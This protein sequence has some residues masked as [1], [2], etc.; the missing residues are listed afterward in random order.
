MARKLNYGIL[1]A[2]LGLYLVGCFSQPKYTSTL[3][4]TNMVNSLTDMT[5]LA[6]LDAPAAK[7][8]CSYD[9][10]NGNDDYNNPLRRENG[11]DVLFDQDG[12][13]YIS[14]FWFTGPE[15]GKQPFEF[16]FDGER[17][18]SLRVTLDDITSLPPIAANEP[19]CWFSY[20]PIP[21][22]KHLK[23]RTTS[24]GYKE[25]GMP[26]LFY[27]INYNQLPKGTEVK[28]YPQA[29]DAAA[30]QALARAQ[31]VWE[32][33]TTSFS[34][35][36]ATALTNVIIPA[37]KS[38]E[39]YQFK[40]PAMLRELCMSLDRSGAKSA[41]AREALLR[42]LII[43][44]YWNEMA[45][46]SVEVPFGD[47]FGSM[48]QRLHYQSL[49]LGCKDDT[50]FVR[51]PMPFEKTARI[52]VENRSPY[53][54]QIGLSGQLEP[55]ASWTNK[56]G[57]FHAAWQKSKSSDVGKPH[58][59]LRTPGRGKYVG[60][61]LGTMSDDKSWW[62][63]EGDELIKVGG[64]EI[65][66]WH[67]TG[68]EDYFDA[69]WYYR[70]ALV[71]AI[72]GLPFKAPFRTIQYRIH[73]TCSVAFSNGIEVAWERGPHNE[74]HGGMESVAYYYLANPAGAASFLGDNQF[75]Q[76]LEDAL[77]AH[78]VMMELN[79]L[80]RLG[81]YSGA[82]E[83][84]DTFLEKYPQFPQADILRVRQLGYRGLKEGWSSVEASYNK[85]LS[86]T[87]TS[88]VLRQQVQK[89]LDFH[90]QSNNVLLGIY[91]NMPTRVYLD[92]QVI[93][94]FSDP[95][96]MSYLIK[97]LSS[98]TK[99]HSLVMQCAW[100]PY[101]FW[102]QGILR[103]HTEDIMTGPNWKIALNPPGKWWET[104]YDDSKWIPVGGLGVKG[105][106]EEPYILLEPNIFVDMMSKPTGM[107]PTAIDWP[108]HN[109]YV[110]YRTVF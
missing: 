9:R 78:T 40:G 70:N 3:P 98:G 24:G 39:L 85:I 38:I 96:R 58:L 80:E 36:H 52:E 21:Y 54:C 49:Y 12:P 30:T 103:T 63:L 48:W 44:I 89:L 77:A 15:N 13:G 67:G 55:L 41:L 4:Y 5:I 99:K 105:P 104:G 45:L 27:Q 110:I 50:Y 43:K 75:R 62:M 61:L 100:R 95:E 10:N 32:N 2:L 107:S 20:V 101:P 88:P 22:Q 46:P 76:P 59:L 31:Q 56:W 11:W 92:G 25:G 66:S 17:N 68:L 73:Q 91:V 60:C 97:Q 74:S 71:K 79:N 14:R 102:V 57:Y 108:D 16:Y 72:H 7:I 37:G 94:D 33:S 23:I 87:N 86:Q 53:D 93:G 18:P 69:G 29:L 6:N 28:S 47:F 34:C 81:D 19:Y 109:G 90:N 26:R 35:E 51:F 64:E 8:V 65:P 106:P 1:A 42:Q 84:I 82:N 83:Y